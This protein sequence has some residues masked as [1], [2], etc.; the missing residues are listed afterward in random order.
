[1]LP[2]MTARTPR[3]ARRAVVAALT[4]AMLIGAAQ[5]ARAATYNFP[6]RGWGHGLGMSQWGARGL[7]EKGLT[8][9]QIIKRYYTGVQLQT[10]TL[11]SEI[12][13]GLLQERNEVYVEGDGPFGLYDSSGT[14]KASGKAGERWTVRPKGTK[15]EV[16]GP[17]ST[18]PKFTS[19]VPVTIR[20]EATGAKI[21]LPQTGKKYGHGRLDIDINA[22]TGKTRAI[23]IL[24]FEQYLYGLA[25]MPASWH[26]EALEAQAIAG[27]TY[28]LEK[29]GRLGQSR[30]V[31]NCAVYASTVDQVYAGTD[32]EVTRWVAAVDATKGLVATYGGKPIQAYYSSSSGGF[33]ENNENVFGGKA[34]PYLRGVCDTGDYV[35]GENPNANWK[36]S[37]EGA[38][39]QSRLRDAG[40]NV[41]TIKKISYLSPRGV[42]GRV[43]AVKDATHG[44]VLVDG[45]IDDARLSGST[46][47]Q[48]LE[49]K[50]NLL[51]PNISGGI[52]LRYDSLSCKPGLATGTDHAWKDLEGTERGREQSFTNGRLIY[53]SVTKKVFYVQ[54]A[55]LARYDAAR[56][57]G[58]DLGLP[59][60][61][62]VSISGGK[63]AT[64]ENGNIYISSKYGARVVTGA[65]LAKYLK[66]GGPGKWGMPT[67]DELPAP[68]GGRSMRFEKAR[69]YWSSKYGARVIYGAILKRYLSLGGA[70]GK[71]GMPTSDEYSI[72]T[73]RRQDFTGGYITF[74]STTGTTAYKLT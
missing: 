72:S 60:A 67:I 13:V 35:G 74:N 71:L 62:G 6:G 30:T 48:I 16:L 8:A 20:Y 9:S 19:G 54:S 3:R 10:K 17:G 21:S 33:T 40:Y 45:T 22:E 11:P 12:R 51:A 29:I 5:T 1:M 39:V 58:T 57:A 44:G 43:L 41:G 68:N 34:L 32:H 7:A 64:F 24:P 56:E 27:R 2:T 25:E 31:C 47:R 55:F 73:G 52:R 46:W 4:V 26:H 23:M 70:S 28:A 38:E 69:I 49:L 63:L 66:S 14:K 15:L 50:S 65:I 53:G 37:Y 59:T 18:T 36:V 42:S 61:D